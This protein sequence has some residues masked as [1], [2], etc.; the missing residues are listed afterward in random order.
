VDDAVAAVVTK[1]TATLAEVVVAMA[2]AVD[3]EAVKGHAAVAVVAAEVVVGP[4]A[5]GVRQDVN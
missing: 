2:A 1:A 3:L 4:V 5:T